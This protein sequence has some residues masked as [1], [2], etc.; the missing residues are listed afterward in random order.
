MMFQ[1]SEIYG[2]W[3]GKMTANLWLVNWTP[4]AQTVLALE[5]NSRPDSPLFHAIHRLKPALGN[6]AGCFSQQENWVCPVLGRSINTAYEEGLQHATS[7]SH[8]YSLSL[9]IKPLEDR[10]CPD[11]WCAD[12]KSRHANNRFMEWCWLNWESLEPPVHP[13]APKLA[14]PLPFLPQNHQI[15][16]LQQN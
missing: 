11:S 6:W 5:P 7:Q 9:Q 1:T 8:M 15:Q 16:L 2:Q 4:A 10:L 14:L 3:Q 13:G 12:R